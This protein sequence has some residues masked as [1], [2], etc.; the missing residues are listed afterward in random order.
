MFLVHKLML[1][2]LN[3]NTVFKVRHISGMFNNK[4]DV[5]FHLQVD[6]F[7]QLASYSDALPTSFPER[8]HPAIIARD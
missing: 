6:R 7:T 3:L 8:L 1:L 4:A 5:L 2:C